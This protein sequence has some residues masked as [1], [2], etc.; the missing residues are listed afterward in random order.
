MSSSEAQHAR[1]MA[2]YYKQ[3]DAL[4]LD[5]AGRIAALQGEFNRLKDEATAEHAA[6]VA[7]CEDCRAGMCCFGAVF[8]RRPNGATQQISN[9]SRLHRPREGGSEI[10]RRRTA[11]RCR[12]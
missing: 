2:V 1:R 3:H 5:R 9:V 10:R 4:H 6:H 12:T 8:L 11:P 7:G